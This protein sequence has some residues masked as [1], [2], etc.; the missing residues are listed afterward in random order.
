M[1]VNNSLNQSFLSANNSK[2][3]NADVSFAAELESAQNSLD[4]TKKLMWGINEDG[5]QTSFYKTNENNKYIVKTTDKNGNESQ[6]II[7]AAKVD[8]TNASVDEMYVY[9]LDLKESGKANFEDSVLKVA[10]AGAKQKIESEHNGTYSS[11]IKINF[12]ELVSDIIA[13]SSSFWDEQNRA[14][15]QEFLALL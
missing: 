5:S 10:M 2:P 8:T 14:S 4:I 7:D 12:K 15:W 11:D 9:A 1:Q 6:K 13:Q 3:K